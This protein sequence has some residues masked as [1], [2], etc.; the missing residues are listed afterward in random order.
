MKLRGVVVALTVSAGLALTACSGATTPPQP[1]ASPAAATAPTS[2]AWSSEAVTACRTFVDAVPN[3]SLV[4]TQL[5]QTHPS[6]AAQWSQTITGWGL[7]TAGVTVPA[8]L[9]ANAEPE[10]H[11][12]LAE[13][14]AALQTTPVNSDN[15]TNYDYVNTR[16]IA[17]K[18]ATAVCAK[19]GV[20]IPSGS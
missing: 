20:T 18:D 19:V 6:T 14:S 13:V 15:S 7:A 5:K 10:V 8:D 1:S 11:K 17:F 16:M 9:G 12:A 4:E 3:W 2:A